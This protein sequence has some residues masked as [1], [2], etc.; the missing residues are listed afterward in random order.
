MEVRIRGW[1]FK[2]GG[3]PEATES[4]E[5]LDQIGGDQKRFVWLDFEGLTT[6]ELES[7]LADC[8][9]WHPIV[10]QHIRMPGRKP[11]LNHFDDYAHLT[12]MAPN[13][14]GKD[15]PRRLID[16]DCVLGHRYLMTF[17][18]QPLAAIDAA[19]TQAGDAKRLV[20]GPDLL[21]Q[22]IVTALIDLFSPQVL[23]MDEVLGEL[24]EEALENPRPDLLERIVLVRDELYMMHLAMAPQ[25]PL[26]SELS[27]GASRLISA[28]ARPFF[29]SAE[30]RL[31]G[32]LDDIS[33]YKEVAQNALELYRS[34]I[35]H[36]TNEII[37]LLT[38]I[39]TPLLI[40]T[41]ITGLYGMN[42]EL[43]GAGSHHAFTVIAFLSG[44]IFVGLLFW[45]KRKGWI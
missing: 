39:S 1:I 45:F 20:R 16:V 17:H 6:P 36:K 13:P 3:A 41:F 42:I 28:Y 31:R 22:R 15:A 19:L 38:V 4:L 35:T 14:A 8:M 10:M 32:L 30:I 23:D 12:L 27:S 37:R 25:V 33:T 29:R 5:A 44:G 40:L 2:Q 21:L 43:P 9:Q 24:E 26:L 34:A 18:R 7:E 11:R